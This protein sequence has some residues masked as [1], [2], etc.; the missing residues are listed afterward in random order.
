[1]SGLVHLFVNKILELSVFFLL[2][3]SIELISA[4]HTVM[5]YPT[6]VR[7]TLQVSEFSS[8]S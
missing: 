3:E 4:H 7:R 5:K 6:R 1:M 8:L 2:T